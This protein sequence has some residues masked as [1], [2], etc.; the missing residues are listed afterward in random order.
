MAYREKCLSFKNEHCKNLQ[1][2]KELFLSLSC[3]IE[4]ESIYNLFPELKYINIW[5]FYAQCSLSMNT[6]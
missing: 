2:C 3:D 6:G 5:H 1:E 4:I